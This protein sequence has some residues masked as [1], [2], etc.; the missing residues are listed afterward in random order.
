QVRGRPADAR[1]DIFALGCVLYE[2]VAG[3]RAFDRDTGADTMSAILRDDPPEL[4][5]SGKTIPFELQRIIRHCLEKDVDQRF[6]S[7]RDLPFD[8]RAVLSGSDVTSATPRPW[9]PGHRSRKI[10]AGVAVSLGLL[11]ALLFPRLL[12]PDKVEAD[13]AI[14]SIAVLPLVNASG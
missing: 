14:D 9:A 3:R 5:D 2:M 13:K 1:S 10:M 4:S 8:L 7:A 6:E 12:G 11:A